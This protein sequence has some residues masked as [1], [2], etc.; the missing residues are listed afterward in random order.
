VNR[1]QESAS[2]KDDGINI[3]KDR[4]LLVNTPLES[5]HSNQENID[6][7]FL[8]I[9]FVLFRLSSAWTKIY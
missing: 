3:G 7:C 8:T 9:E 2:L 1:I 5:A 4:H 6:K